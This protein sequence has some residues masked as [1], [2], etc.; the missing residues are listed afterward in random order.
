[1]KE[2]II[3]L[4]KQKAKEG[5]LFLKALEK[6]LQMTIQE[7]EIFTGEKIEIIHKDYYPVSE[8]IVI[9]KSFRNRKDLIL[10]NHFYLIGGNLQLLITECSCCDVPSFFLR[11]DKMLKQ[12]NN[13]QIKKDLKIKEI[14]SEEVIEI[15]LQL[16]GTISAFTII[17]FCNGLTIFMNPLGDKMHIGA[18]MSGRGYTQNVVILSKE[19]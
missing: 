13:Q 5:S 19:E 14:T 17:G 15:I 12:K 8:K 4:I 18:R 1:M 6:L 2:Y 11:G 3:S 7:I 16:T 10:M 9:K